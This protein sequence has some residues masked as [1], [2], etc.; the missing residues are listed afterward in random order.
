MPGKMADRYRPIGDYALIGDTRTAALVSRDGSIDWLCLPDFHS[1]SIFAA[2]LDRLNGG[3]MRIG[4][5]AEA[6]I[7][8][9]Y[10]DNT[11]VLRTRF[12]TAD[13][14]LA[15]T[16][17]MPTMAGSGD[18]L[19]PERQLLRIVDVEEGAVE[20][21]FQATCRPGYADA[22]SKLTRSGSQGWTISAGSDAYLLR[23]DLT[24][25]R[26]RDDR[27]EGVTR[28]EAGQRRYVSLSYTGRDIGIVPALAGET[29]EKLQGTLDWWD[30]WEGR[31]DYDGPWRD[32]VMR[33]AMTLRLL[34]CSQSGAVIA[35]PTC[36]LPEAIGG[37]RNWDYRYCWP[38]DSGFIL[39]GFSG[40]GQTQEADAFFAWLLHAT[41]LT[42]PKLAAVYDLYGGTSIGEQMLKQFEGYR[43]SGPVHRGNGAMNQLQL[44][45][46]GS[47]IE[48]VYQH[49]Q[50]GGDIEPN[51]ADILHDL[52]RTVCDVWRKP[53]DGIWEFRGPRRHTTYGKAMC[54]CALDRL[55]RLARD[56]AIDIDTDRFQA[57][58]DEVKAVILD[59]AWNEDRQAYTGAFGHDYLDAAVLTLPRLGLVEAN[60]P[61]MRATW[62]RIMDELADGPLIHRYPHGIDGFASHEGAFGICC[63]WAVEYLARR[64]DLA[65]ARSRFEALLGY[66][67]DLGLFAEEIDPATGEALGNYPQALTHVGLINAALTIHAAEQAARPGSDEAGA[68]R[69]LRP[70][71]ASAPSGAS[72]D[73]RNGES[74]GASRQP[75]EGWSSSASAPRSRNGWS[76]G[77]PRGHSRDRGNLL[78]RLI[79]IPALARLAP[80]GQPSERRGPRSPA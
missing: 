37:T 32:A 24:V 54:W 39:G 68:F 79:A 63:F 59:E 42:R 11:P 13:G 1:P 65:E 72:R 60:D 74:P 52:G 16:D 36:S 66:G 75:R 57:E 51:E 15:L 21:A 48:A 12:R 45:V 67:S 35:A 25:A 70:S 38:R 19:E 7:A 78:R 6:E 33:S 58:A 76:A 61:R 30:E 50:H 64:G 22:P 34:T 17:F 10:I 73:S 55:L 46:Y 56:G 43:G 47:V 80:I 53:D 31:I 8:R 28:L 4:P 9:D 2:I 26:G 71:R 40:L 62:D 18:R 27:L 20:V 29:E 77:A 5:T 23:T 41:R 49:A 14:V 3:A 44:D 69:P